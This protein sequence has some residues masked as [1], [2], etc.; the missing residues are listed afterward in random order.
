M[1]IPA[2]SVKVSALERSKSVTLNHACSGKQADVQP[3]AADGFEALWR[4][5]ATLADFSGVRS[6]PILLKNSVNWE[7]ASMS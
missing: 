6:W 7:F 2:A 4:I 1:H 3:D 5:H